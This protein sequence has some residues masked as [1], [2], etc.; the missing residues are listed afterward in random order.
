MPNK[1]SGLNYSFIRQNF[2][3]VDI[4]TLMRIKKRYPLYRYIITENM[5][6]EGADKLYNNEFFA[7]YKF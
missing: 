2:N 5:D 1:Q 3:K 4:S 7:L 6:L